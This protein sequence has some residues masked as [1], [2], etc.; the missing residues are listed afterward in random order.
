ML[1]LKDC[2]PNLTQSIHNLSSLHYYFGTLLA[3]AGYGLATPKHKV[4]RTLTCFQIVFNFL[5]SSRNLSI[6]NS[7]AISIELF[8]ISAFEYPI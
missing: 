7:V 1:M 2:V 4:I 3:F 5:Q 8:H 6:E